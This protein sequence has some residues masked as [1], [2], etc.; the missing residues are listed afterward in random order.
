MILLTPCTN[1][2]RRDTKGLF[3]LLAQIK[4]DPPKVLLNHQ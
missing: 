1:I 3:V 2:D 4:S